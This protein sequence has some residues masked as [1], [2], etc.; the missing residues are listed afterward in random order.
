MMR[1]M[2]DRPGLLS[3]AE[4]AVRLGVSPRTLKR[5]ISD[6]DLSA[7][8]IGQQWRIAISDIEGF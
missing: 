1:P 6:G 8:K 2:T 5:R 7:H 4:V 3:V